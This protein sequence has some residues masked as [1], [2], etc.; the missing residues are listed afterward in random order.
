MKLWHAELNK[1]TATT[2]TL[3]QSA[4]SSDYLTQIELDD[5]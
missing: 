5:H 4:F 2:S 3:S 1:V